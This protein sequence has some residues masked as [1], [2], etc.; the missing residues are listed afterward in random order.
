MA[1]LFWEGF[2][3]NSSTS[4]STNLVSVAGSSL[5][6]GV[7]QPGWIQSG[8]GSRIAGRFA[9]TTY[10]LTQ[11]GSGFNID[12]QT[13]TPDLWF[14]GSGARQIAAMALRVRNG[15]ATLG[16]GWRLLSFKDSFTNTAA[17]VQV[18]VGFNS[19]T[20]EVI[21]YRGAQVAEIGRSAVE[22]FSDN[23]WFWFEIDLTIGS[24]DGAIHARIN[25]NTIYNQTGLNTQNTANAFAR[26]LRFH[27]PSQAGGAGNFDV[28]DILVMDTSGATFN[29][30]PGEARIDCIRPS[31]DVQAQFTRTG[32]SSN[33]D[34]I[35][36][37][38]LT[39]TDYVDAT[40]VGQEDIYELDDVATDLAILGAGIK[41]RSQRTGNTLYTIQP[42]LQ[43]GSGGA[44][45]NLTARPA[46][47]AVRALNEF[48]P[49]NPAT[50]VAWTP[51]EINALR[52][53]LLAGSL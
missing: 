35:A 46:Q 44:I 36:D 48:A 53:R 40:A 52:L 5:V 24:A 6:A 39:T 41:Y 13:N 4:F 25:G 23:A 9:G 37:D 12:T 27:A 38:G 8:N 21:F 51:A 20:G 11:P 17:T 34:A 19:Q 33:A 30:F 3:W 42:R 49:I 45:S 15:G 26:T 2:D 28:D 32:G 29:S 16:S 50:G 1:L 22:V 14:G 10:A 7:Q 18:S 31:S 47:A 43:V